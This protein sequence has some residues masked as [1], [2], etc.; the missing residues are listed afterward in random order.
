MERTAGKLPL[1]ILV[2]ALVLCIGI[3]GR[4]AL[5]GWVNVEGRVVGH[6]FTDGQVSSGSVVNGQP[7]Q[8]I[9]SSPDKYTLMVEVNGSVSS[10]EVSANLYGRVLAGQT[11]VKMR[12]NN[13]L[14]LCG[15]VE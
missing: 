11:T 12:C 8:V 6:A 13:M 15:V 14:V 2:I 7:S 3:A 5:N 4:Y 1:L 9:V 10:Y